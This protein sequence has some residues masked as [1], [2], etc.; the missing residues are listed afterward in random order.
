MWQPDSQVG[1]VILKPPPIPK[2]DHE[3]PWI[4]SRFQEEQ[5]VKAKSHDEEHEPL[6][7]DTSLGQRR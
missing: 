2:I 6:E 1:M 4:K 3:V 5:E 7:G